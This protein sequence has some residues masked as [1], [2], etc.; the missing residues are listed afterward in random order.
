MDLTS[1]NAYVPLTNINGLQTDRTHDVTVSLSCF[2]LLYVGQLLDQW[3][4]L[5]SLRTYT[6]ADLAVDIGNEIRRAL[7]TRRGRRQEA[8]EAGKR[9]TVKIFCSPAEFF[10]LFYQFCSLGSLSSLISHSRSFLRFRLSFVQLSLIL[11]AGWDRIH[12]N[13]TDIH[14]VNPDQAITI[15]CQYRSPYTDYSHN[16]PNCYHPDL[17]Q[18]PPPPPGQLH[19]PNLINS[20]MAFSHC[21]PLS[22]P[23][24]PVFYISICFSHIFQKVRH[25]LNI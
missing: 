22:H 3:S 21:S 20:I 8:S 18:L 9:M 24:E 25:P 15:T 11:N 12:Y 7:Y 17:T 2:R 13:T 6:R 23:A 1:P 4:W 19:P 14:C 5:W 16:P 10:V